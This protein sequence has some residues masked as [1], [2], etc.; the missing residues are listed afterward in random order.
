MGAGMRLA[1]LRKD[2]TTFPVRIGLT[3]VTTVSGQFTL[4]VVRD[5][6]WAGPILQPVCLGE[7]RHARLQHAHASLVRHREVEP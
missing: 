7:R 6:T 4:A 3:P 1:G 2:G 5:I